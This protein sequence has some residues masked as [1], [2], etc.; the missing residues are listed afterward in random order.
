M[1]VGSGERK[2]KTSVKG[3]RLVVLLGTTLRHAIPL[4]N[5]GTLLFHGGQFLRGSWSFLNAGALQVTVL[6]GG[7]SSSQ[8]ACDLSHR[9]ML[10]FRAFRY[11]FSDSV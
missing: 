9:G 7:S 10:I 6:D 5:S 8:R 2:S 1:L 11:L 4:G 3:N